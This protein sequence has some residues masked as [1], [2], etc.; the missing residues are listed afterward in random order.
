MGPLRRTRCLLPGPCRGLPR[1]RI[2]AR[3]TRPLPGCRL[4]ASR[5]IRRPSSAPGRRTRGRVTRRT[6][7]TPRSATP[8]QRSQRRHRRLSA[9]ST[10]MGAP[11]LERSSSSSMGA[12]TSGIRLPRTLFQP[13]MQIKL[14]SGEPPLNTEPL[15]RLTHTASTRSHTAKS[16][17]HLHQTQTLTEPRTLCRERIVSEMPRALKARRGGC[18]RVWPWPRFIFTVR[19]SSL[20]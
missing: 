18:A 8:C 19:T 13:K 14:L 17:K 4:P 9:A 16:S 6:R 15:R 12:T 2:L 10:R 3:I 1:G 5:S 7:A 11:T 20:V